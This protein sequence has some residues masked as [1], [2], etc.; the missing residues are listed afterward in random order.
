MLPIGIAF[1]W[2]F[3]FPNELRYGESRK[4]IPSTALLILVSTPFIGYTYGLLKRRFKKAPSLWIII[5]QFVSLCGSILALTLFDEFFGYSLPMN[6][7]QDFLV[8]PGLDPYALITDLPF[9]F[10]FSI[11]V[12]NQFTL[13]RNLWVWWAVSA[14]V[15]ILFQWL[16]FKF[17]KKS[18]AAL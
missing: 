13:I 3:A 6:F 12:D 18:N 14:I 17:K 4:L 11:D 5:P 10:S 16:L 15:P 8:S 9:G 2:V 7:D 1:L